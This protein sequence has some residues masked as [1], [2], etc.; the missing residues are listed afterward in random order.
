MEDR[1]KSDCWVLGWTLVTI[2]IESVSDF[3]RKLERASRIAYKSREISQDT[4]EA[5][6]YHLG[7]TNFFTKSPSVSGV[8]S[9]KKE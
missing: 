9:Y 6:L 2:I 3:I 5:F 8:L 1:E 4:R 7:L